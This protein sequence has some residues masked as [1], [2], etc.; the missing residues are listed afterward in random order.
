MSERVSQ[1]TRFQT[2]LAFEL[3]GPIERKLTLIVVSTTAVGMLLASLAIIAYQSFVFTRFMISE[4]ETTAEILGKNGTAALRFQ[5]N[6]DAERILASLR[7][8]SHI[9]SAC[10]LSPDNEVFAVYARDPELVPQPDF[11]LVEGYTISSK[12]L[13]WVKSIYQDGDFIGTIHIESDISVLYEQVLRSIF[14]VLLIT[15]ASASIALLLGFKF[16]HTVSDPINHLGQQIELARRERAVERV[17]AEAM[18]MRGSDDLRNVAAVLF[19]EINKL[20]FDS[21]VTS[22]VLI[23]EDRDYRIDYK[24][25]DNPEIHGLSWSSSSWVAYDKNTMVELSQPMS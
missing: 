6:K 2:S 23:D 4:L 7:A 24:A 3:R 13:T 22:I 19:Q 11:P 18:A 9:S 17:R 21:P 10:F 25:M 14:V 15:I 20:G 16:L 5:A 12:R 1:Y 8:K